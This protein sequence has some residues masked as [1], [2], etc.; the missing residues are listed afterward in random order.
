MTV[1]NKWPASL[2]ECPL[3]VGYGEDKMDTVISTTIDAGVTKKRRRTSLKRTD[4]ACSFILTKEETAALEEF[5]EE[6]LKRVAQFTWFHPRTG[7]PVIGRFVSPP[8]I[9]HSSAEYYMASCMI[10]VEE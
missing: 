6:V 3:S 9:S 4:I 8:A 2:P 7:N 10:E 5:Y 1:T